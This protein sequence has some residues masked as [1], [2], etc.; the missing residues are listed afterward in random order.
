MNTAES[1]CLLHSVPLSFWGPALTLSPSPDTTRP[2]KKNEVDGKDYYFVSTE[3]MTRDISANEFLEFGSYQGNMFGTK[4][5]T[6]HKIHQQDKV[7]IL[8]IEPQVGSRGR[9]LAVTVPAFSSQRKKP[10][11]PGVAFPFPRCEYSEGVPC[12]STHLAV[13]PR[14]GCCGSGLQGP[15]SRSPPSELMSPKRGVSFSSHCITDTVP[16][17]LAPSLGQGHTLVTAPFSPQTLKIVRTAE[18]SPFIVFIAPT[19]KA[20]EVSEWQGVPS[21]PPLAGLLGPWQHLLQQPRAP[22]QRVPLCLAF[23]VQNSVQT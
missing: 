10:A 7:A 14:P 11:S 19:D 15:F 2:Q 8:D 1:W 13:T 9:V 3:E 18:L 22:H 6:V 21:C 23:G 20:E 16:A 12:H 4:F 5:E 17:V